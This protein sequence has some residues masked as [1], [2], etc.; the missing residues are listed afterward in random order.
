[1]A[2]LQTRYTDPLIEFST[3]LR[4]VTAVIKFNFLY[5]PLSYT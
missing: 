3:G 4:P 5:R 1:M 2:P